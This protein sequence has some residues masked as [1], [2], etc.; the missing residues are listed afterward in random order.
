MRGVRA[1]THAEAVRILKCERDTFPAPHRDE[2]RGLYGALTLAIASLE[3][4]AR[5][6]CSQCGG[7]VL[8]MRKC[9]GCEVAQDR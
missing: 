8:H 1:V 2:T 5:E 4:E 9:R 6:R 7:L 3:R